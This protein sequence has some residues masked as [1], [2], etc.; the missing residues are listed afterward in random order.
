MQRPLTVDLPSFPPKNEDRASGIRT[1]LESVYDAFVGALDVK[2]DAPVNVAW[3]AKPQPPRAL[4]DHRPFEVR[5]NAV[6][7]GWSQYAYQFA[8]ELCHVMTN[9]DRVR[10]HRHKWFEESLCEMASLFV[11]YRLADDWHANPPSGI[12]GSRWLAPDHAKYARNV[13]GGYCAPARH[14]LPKWLENNIHSMEEKSTLRGLNGIVAVSLLEYFQRDPSFWL[15]CT[16]LNYWDASGDSS[17]GDYLNSW[18]AC[19][20]SCGGLPARTPAVVRALFLRS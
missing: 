16:R 2:L 7:N 12:S 1:T 6:G 14:D 15:D 20:K 5:I 4:F 17:F 3:W 19:L 13:E 9:F 18:E 11:L 10:K 8:H